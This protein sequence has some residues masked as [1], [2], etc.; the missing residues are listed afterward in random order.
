MRRALAPLLI[1]VFA[2]LGFGGCGDDEAAT[3]DVRDVNPE[4]VVT[5]SK[6]PRKTGEPVP[7]ENSGVASKRPQPKVYV[8]DEDPPDELV[9][10]DIVEGKGPAATLGDE[11]RINFIAA[12]Y[13]TGELYESSWNRP[14][15]ISF[16]LEPGEAVPA[17]LEGIPGMKEGGRRQLL[18]PGEMALEGTFPEVDDSD[19]AA[20]AYVIDLIEVK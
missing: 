13:L 16:T 3:S 11:L 19:E 17:W 8:P 5:T 14:R 10:E 20:L 4:F 7:I 2:A 15:P 12:R 6:P 18:V 9:V 1:L